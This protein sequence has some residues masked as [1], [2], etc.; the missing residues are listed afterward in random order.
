MTTDRKFTDQE[1][2]LLTEEEREGLLDD[3]ADEGEDD[4]DGSDDTGADKGAEGDD[5]AGADDGNDDDAGADGGDGADQAAA[6][7]AAA[8]AAEAEAAAKLAAD[9]AAKIAAGDAGAAA[10]GDDQA[11]ADASNDADE[12][13]PAWV[14]AEDLS[15]KKSELKQQ[16]ANLAKT[17]DAGDLTAEEY[18]ARRE[19]IEDEREE[20]LTREIMVKTEKNI[21]INAW[22]SE[23]AS[24]V[25][26]KPQYQPGG[27]LHKVL[28]TKVR[29][30][31]VVAV[32][33]LSPK[34][35]AKAHAEIQAALGLPIG[36]TETPTPKPAPTT[37]PAPAARRPAPPPTLAQI[38][39]TDITDADD[40]AEFTHLD[41]LLER[42][43]VRFE[44]ELARLSPADRDRYL[45]R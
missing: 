2:A 34:L 36:K 43:S 27:M 19:E 44:Q 13:R 22:K 9:E 32:N 21:A 23:V 28:D 6:D 7:A 11:G 42:D 14:D 5:G 39:A 1:L 25:K 17:F 29:E 8:A 45:A 41:Q 4:D 20:L 38:P 33:P 35:L 10:A 12:K 31:Q 40:G 16:L 37:P 30:L 18:Q 3:D 24:F 15:G 26:D